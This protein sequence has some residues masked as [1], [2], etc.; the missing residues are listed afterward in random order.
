MSVTQ[1]SDLVQRADSEH[2]T[3]E[4]GTDYVPFDKREYSFVD[5]IATWFG[6][7]VNT[8]SWF[9]AVWRPRWAWRLYSSTALFTCRC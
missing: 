3:D 4:Y 1:D 5:Q 7:G 6:S 8:G 2:G 9:S